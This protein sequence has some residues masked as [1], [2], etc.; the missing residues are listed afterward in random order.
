MSFQQF[1]NEIGRVF[2]CP[3]QEIETNAT[4]SDLFRFIKGDLLITAAPGTKTIY[5]HRR[6]G[7]GRFDMRSGMKLEVIA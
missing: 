4:A 6:Q 1:K 7:N 3:A 5:C 2:H